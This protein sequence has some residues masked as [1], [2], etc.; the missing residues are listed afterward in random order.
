MK[1]QSIVLGFMA[2]LSVPGAH[3]VNQ[4]IRA[5][6]QPD[7]SQPSKNVFVNKTPN[8]GYCAQYPGQCADNGTFSIQVPVRF[9]SIRQITPGAPA[10]ALS[11]KVPAN[12]RPLTVINQAT[13]DS[14]TVEV[15]ITGIGSEYVLSE[16]A[17][18]LVG[19][20]DDL[21]GH[22]RLWANNSWV[23]APAPCRYSGVGAF[24]PKT[25]RFFWKAP[26]E[27]WCSKVAAYRIPA[28]SFDTFDFAYELRTPNPLHMSSGQYTGSLSYT[29]GPSGDFQMGAMMVPND[30][31]LTLDFVL[32]VQ[33]ELKVDLPPGGNKVTMEPVGGWQRWIDTGR[34]PTEIYRDQLFYLSASTRFKVMMICNS[35]GGTECSIGNNEV[36]FSKFQVRLTVPGGIVGPGNHDGWSGTLVHNTWLGPF[37]PSRYVDRKAGNLRFEIP[38]RWIESLLKPGMNGTLW[39]N[40]TVIFDSE[41]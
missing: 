32:D 11:L 1:K 22:Q 31:N 36:G 26:V 16:T 27:G 6:F 19:V 41:V 30:G 40:A 20:T 18:S 29:L 25:Y 33:H 28:M 38:R 9:D 5:L 10:D 4:E 39:G 21:E 8:S 35:L 34:M 24:S 23:Y 2:A 12:W 7:P 17:A 3:G 37:E 15:R 13:G 14:E